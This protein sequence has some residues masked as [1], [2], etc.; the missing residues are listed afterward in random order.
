MFA[1]NHAATGLIIKKIYP[2]VPMVVILVSVQLIEILW[3]VLN[4]LGVEK[5]ITEDKVQS[6]SDVHLKFMPFSHS[7]VSTA[8]LAAGAWIVLDLGFKA[9]DMGTAVALGI[10]SHLVLDLISHAR[11]IVIAPF[12]DSRKFGLGLYEKPPFAFVFETIY[13]IFCWWLYG[14]SAAL[15]WIIIVFNIANA[16]FFIKAI[17]GP[18]R[19]MAH[20]PFSITAIIALQI[21]VTAVLVGLYS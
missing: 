15:F 18:E 8:V 17:P 1:I 12:L 21:I 7:L 14:G 4:F 6:V 16:S 10:C 11:D 2:D 9:A 3:V 19:L 5:T 20:R 13:G